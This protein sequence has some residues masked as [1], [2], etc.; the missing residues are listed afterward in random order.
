MDGEGQGNKGHEEWN[1]AVVGKVKHMRNERR[2]KGTSEV[3]FIEIVI[4]CIKT[5]TSWQWVGT[6]LHGIWILGERDM[7]A[8]GRL[9]ALLFVLGMGS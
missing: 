2:K 6:V 8:Y 3:K 7:H 9:G 1:G 4:Q 5:G